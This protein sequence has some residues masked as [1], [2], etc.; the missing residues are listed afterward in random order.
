M[1]FAWQTLT[2]LGRNVELQPGE[3][4]CIKRDRKSISKIDKRLIPIYKSPGEK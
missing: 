4:A 3:K 2:K 1:G